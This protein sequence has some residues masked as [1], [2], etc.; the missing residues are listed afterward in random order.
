MYEKSIIHIE[1]E[2]LSYLNIVIVIIVIIIIYH[3]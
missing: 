1:P 3:Q 2:R